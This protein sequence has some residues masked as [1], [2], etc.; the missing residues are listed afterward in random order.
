MELNHR[1]YRT[2]YEGEEINDMK[3]ETASY[4][5][6]PRPN[7]FTTPFTDTAIVLGNGL[8]RKDPGI[9][10]L[11]S[12]NSKKVAEAYKL[13][14]ACNR[15][16]EDEMKYDYYVIRNRKFLANVPDSQKY[17]VYL[18][19]D[20][21]L[22]YSDVHNLIPNISYFDAGASAAYL[23]CFDG[24]KKVFLM[25]FDGDYGNGFK[26]V[27]DGTD[28][29]GDGNGNIDYSS[30]CMYLERVMYIYSD[31]QFYRVQIDAAAPPPAWLNLPNFQNVSFREAVML[32]DF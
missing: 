16:I 1:Y 27:Y 13:V 29:Y 14:Y 5:V 21:F 8:T 25:G 15:A 7:V 20:I 19:N 11:L 24:H 3:G 31:V 9:Q 6:K 18:P 12:I 17:Q 2:S 10:K 4:A 32:G 28:G 22:D 26:T 30:W 23:A